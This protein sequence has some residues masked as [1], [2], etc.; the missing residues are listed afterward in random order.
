MGVMQLLTSDACWC[1]SYSLVTNLGTQEISARSM[2]SVAI[3]YLF[4]TNA[5]GSIEPL[6][7]CAISKLDRSVPLRLPAL[8]NGDKH[9]DKHGGHT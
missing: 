4:G 8:G 6:A 1:R 5:A 2:S 7:L 9:R 3:V